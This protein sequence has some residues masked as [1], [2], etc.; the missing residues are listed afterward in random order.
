MG[1][2]RIGRRRL[3]LAAATGLAVVSGAVAVIPP[4]VEPERPFDDVLLGV[5]TG[6]G[7]LLY[8]LVGVVVLW[9]RP[10]NGIG[11]VALLIGLGFS[12]ALI[13]SF[14]EVRLGLS[15]AF[16]LASQ[17]VIFV[18]WIAGGSL[19]VV[20]FPDGHRTSRLGGLVEVTLVAAVVG[21]IVTSSRDDLP[22]DFA[23]SASTVGLFA[24]ADV[25]GFGG[26]GL[27]YLGSFVDLALRYRR[28][29]VVAATQMRWVLAA[30]AVSLTFLIG[31]GLF[32]GT[33]DWLFV[34][35]FASMGLPVFAIAVAITRY[36]LYEIDRIV[37][38]S[39]SY[40]IL[41]AV[42]F[43]AFGATTLVLQRLV[44]SAVAPG[45][46]LEPWVVA[47]STLVVAA[48]FNPVRTRVQAV[49]DR[50]FNRERYD[51][52]GIVA[53]FAGRLRGQIDLPT[54]SRE[55]AATTAHALEPSTTAVWLRPRA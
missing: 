15:S 43:A 10:G 45:G 28:A 35:W 29:D 33:Q 54:V 24:L 27:A 17:A 7:A 41:T 31:L 26:L 22:A 34:A 18:G 16:V 53:G 42:L 23:Y 40:V 5:I 51:S 13:L 39:I 11:R 49:V 4:L 14:L 1:G 9:N 20:W 44:S 46:E 12:S 38:R 50:R 6:Y 52:A 48:L 36:H 55:L 8:V 32:G 2:A 30:E 47:A 19:L 25:V 21:L 3:G 37:S